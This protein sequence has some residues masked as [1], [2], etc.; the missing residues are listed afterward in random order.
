[1]NTYVIAFTLK[2]RG[3]KTSWIESI[4]QSGIRDGESIENMQI[5]DLTEYFEEK[6]SE[7]NHGY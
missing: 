2:Q 3:D 6:E 5:V 4:L 7:N 1:M